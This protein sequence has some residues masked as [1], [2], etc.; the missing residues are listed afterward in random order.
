IADMKI[1][2]VLWQAFADPQGAG[3]VK[4]VYFPNRHLPMRAALINRAA[5][6][7]KSRAF[8]EVYAWMPVLSYDLAPTIAR[9][10][11]W[12]PE[13]EAVAVAPDQYRR[14][15]PFD[16]VAR[17]QIIDLYEDL[18]SHAIFN[19]IL[20]HDDALLSDFE[21]AGPQALVAY[22]SAG[23]RGSIRELRAD[24]QSLQ[25][26]TGY[27]SQYLTEFTKTLAQ[28]VRD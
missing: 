19:G 14:L 6:Q 4:S 15:S 23:L 25:R 27:K 17:R 1:T 8:V 3:L 20:F 24:P 26:W 2:T 9:V 7:L 28:H 22:K 12:D 11:S 10:T 5:W 21:D 16:P 13:T 18:A